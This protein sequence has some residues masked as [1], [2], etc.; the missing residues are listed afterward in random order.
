[1]HWLPD[2]QPPFKKALE[3]TR[4]KPALAQ[5]AYFLRNHDEIDLGRLTTQQRNEVYLTVL[6]DWDTEFKAEQKKAEHLVCHNCG[7]E[8]RQQAADCPNCGDHEFEP[9]VY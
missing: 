1:M 9:A 2:R 4:E 8:I 7:S 5:W 6:P 3:E